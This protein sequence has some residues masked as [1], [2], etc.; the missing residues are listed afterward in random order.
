[1][2]K[3]NLMHIR[4][5]FSEAI[6]S[7]KDLLISEMSLLK[8]RKN[9]DNY[10]KLRKIELELKERSKKELKEILNELKKIKTNALPKIEIP[11]ILKKD[12]EIISKTKKSKKS[13][14]ETTSEDD[15]EIQLKEIREQLKQIS[16]Y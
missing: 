16:S 11:D 12:E 8:I 14:F 7:K 13:D 3:D 1:M 2:K 4:V 5:N 9:I 6:D 15:I 10:R